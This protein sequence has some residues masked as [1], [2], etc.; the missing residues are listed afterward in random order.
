[1]D[2]QIR[3]RSG[4]ATVRNVAG[5]AEIR[6]TDGIAGVK[7]EGTSLLLLWRAKAL[8]QFAGGTLLMM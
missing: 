1:M 3:S 5:C 8:E 2:D 6:R 7:Q 4:A